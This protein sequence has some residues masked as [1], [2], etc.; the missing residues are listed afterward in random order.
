[1][2]R[3]SSAMKAFHDTM[4]SLGVSDKVTAFTASEFGRTLSSNGD[5]T[6]HGWGGHQFVVGGAVNKGFYGYAPPVSV[7]STTAPADQ[8]HVGQGR[9]LP[10]TSVDQMAATLAK[11]F[12]VSDTELMGTVGQNYRDALL[13][14][15]HNF[16]GTS[17]GVSYATDMGFMKP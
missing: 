10:T 14:N 9:L 5:G 17:G 12:G 11:W 6:D 16:G 8:W 2:G 15:L 4:V 7:S 3:V 1:M 13:P